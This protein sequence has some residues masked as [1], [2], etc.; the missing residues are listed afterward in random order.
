MTTP[1]LSTAVKDSCDRLLKH[2]FFS[3]VPKDSHL[4]VLDQIL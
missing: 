1:S 3:A 2:W 4:L